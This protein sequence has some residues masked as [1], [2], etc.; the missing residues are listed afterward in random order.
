[1][2]TLAA[3][4]FRMDRVFIRRIHTHTHTPRTY[5]DI[6]TDTHSV[7]VCDVCA[8]VVMCAIVGRRIGRRRMANTF[9]GK[10]GH[11]SLRR[12]TRIRSTTYAIYH[13]ADSSRNS[14]TEKKNG[15]RG[16]PSAIGA[17]VCVHLHF[18]RSA[19]ALDAWPVF[20]FKQTPTHSGHVYL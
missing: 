6:F 12:P 18:D 4:A 14:K 20:V 9:H 15:R 1:M 19:D 17:H 13:A 16:R 11:S 3:G 2:R 5:A 8:S 10:L 7:S